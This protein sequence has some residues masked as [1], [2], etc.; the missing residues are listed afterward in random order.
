M[1]PSA[2]PHLIQLPP[3]E[4]EGPGGEPRPGGADHPMRVITRRIAIDGEWTAEMRAEVT[5]LFSRLAPE[6]DASRRTPE[7]I[8]ALAD[9]FDRTGVATEG[10]RCLELGAGTGIFTGSLAE[11]FESVIAAD[12]TEAMVRQVDPAKGSAVVADG[13]VLPFAT[14]SFEVVVLVNMFLFAAE[15]DRVLAPSGTVVWFNSRGEHTPIHLTTR[16]L[17][18]ALPGGWAATESRRGTATWATLSR[19]AGPL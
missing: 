11:R 12:I 15:L 8:E 4:S 19:R 17:L 16:E 2:E 7:R 6:W 3:V 1:S 14:D 18:T 13:S 10:R 9:A 5:E